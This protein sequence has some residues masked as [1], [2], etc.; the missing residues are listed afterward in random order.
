MAENVITKRPLKYSWSHQLWIHRTLVKI[1]NSILRLLPFSIKYGIGK[2]LKKNSLPY[3]LID[4]NFTIIQVGAPIDTLGSGRSRG[5][6]FSLFNKG[7]KGQTI[8]IEPAQKSKEKFLQYRQQHGIDNMTFIH[9]GAWNSEQVLK[10][11]FDPSHP[12]TNFAAGTV[13][14]SEEELKR[15]TLVEI[16]SNTVDSL[17]EKLNLE[18]VDLVSLTT[19]GSEE[20]ILEGMQGLLDKGLKYIALAGGEEE[21]IEIMKKFG[22]QFLSY[23]DRGATFVRKY[24]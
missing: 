24:T 22:Y 18:K 15:F 10:F 7:N 17:I 5:M 12:A 20:Q 8:I 21:D 3:S 2:S 14:Y 4:D 23:D 16:P 13:D 11:Y 9:S 6:Y 19:N 1:A